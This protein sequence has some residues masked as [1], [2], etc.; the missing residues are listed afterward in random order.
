M[1]NHCRIGKVTPKGNLTILPG[2][3]GDKRDT[4]VV[5]GRIT[6][7]RLPKIEGYVL[8]AWTEH[9]GGNYQFFCDAGNRDVMELP[10]YASE[11]MRYAITQGGK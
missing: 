9:R 2:G 1:E 5:A 3:Y 4:V 11:L 8:L 6:A 7:Q 10:T